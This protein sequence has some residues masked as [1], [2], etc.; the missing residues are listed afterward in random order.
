MSLPDSNTSHT[1]LVARL[2]EDDDSL[3]ENPSPLIDAML[4]ERLFQYSWPTR[5]LPY[6]VLFAGFAAFRQEV[7]WI[8]AVGITLLYTLGT[9]WLDHQRYGF[10]EDTNRQQRWQYWAQRFTIGSSVTGAAW[11]I[12]FWLHAGTQDYAQQAVLC[13][14]WSGLALSNSNTRAPHLPAFY[15]FFV[16]LALPLF[17]RVLI[18]GGTPQYVMGLFGIVL[19]ITFCIRAH[20]THRQERVSLALR[21]RNAEL[22]ADIDRARAEATAAH[23]AAEQALAA[24]AQS[25]ATAERL[26][27]FGSW[28]WTLEDDHLMWSDN[29]FR[30][31]NLSPSAAPAAVDVL[32]DSTHFADRQLVT[33]F[34]TTLRREGRP[35]EVEFRVGD[36]EGQYGPRTWRKMRLMGIARRDS[37]GRIVA[38]CGTLR[39]LREEASRQ[40]PEKAP[41]PI[42]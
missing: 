6:V 24:R 26:A 38:L 29:M 35:A 32:V 42:S 22:V 15:A 30:M 16:M 1:A 31:L 12:F 21:L 9:W 10:A 13:V 23:V 40:P 14:M 28:E 33:Q 34:F 2:A 18:D 39:D 17:A 41:P 11:G 36:Q 8:E 37:T 5:Y 20:S 3:L 4:I 27:G 19:A 25:Y 7:D